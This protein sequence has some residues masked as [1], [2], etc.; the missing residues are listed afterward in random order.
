M[1]DLGYTSIVSSAW[2]ND[3]ASAREELEELAS[4][5][6]RNRDGLYNAA[7]AAAQLVRILGKDYPTNESAWK[8]QAIDLLRSAY[9][10]DSRGSFRAEFDPDFAPLFD[11]P[12]FQSL[13]VE[14]R[15]S[16]K[17]AVVW[18]RGDDGEQLF[19]IELSLK[20][21][22][23][24]AR[25]RI[26][27]GFSPMAVACNT[28]PG[29]TPECSV[30]WHRVVGTQPALQEWDPVQRTTFI[31]AFPKWPGKIEKLA[32]ILNDSHDSADDASLRS[33]MSLAVGSIRDPGLTARKAWGPVLDEWHQNAE[34][35]GLH[36]ASGWALK[37]WGLQLKDPVKGERDGYEW[38]VT[39]TGT[40]MIRIPAGMVERPD[41][42]DTS[43][44]ERKSIS[45]KRDFWLAHAS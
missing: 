12:A 16:R 1:G 26:S 20:H 17:Y 4:R 31:E 25:Q 28:T 19:D 32:A 33:G 38:F 36:R 39:E 5:G 13:V 3:G 30:V 10:M 43:Q 44:S 14:Q 41:D 35:A 40:T 18:K 15:E 34:D 6:D 37:S 8:R 27:D 2:L 24:A 7:R 11:D 9:S 23:E 42:P 21:A 45:I 22:Q 29:E